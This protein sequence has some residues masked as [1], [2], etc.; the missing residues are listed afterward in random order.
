[1]NEIIWGD[2]IFQLVFLVVLAVIVALI[3]LAVRTL[4]K[5]SKRMDRSVTDIIIAIVILLALWFAFE[6]IGT[7]NASIMVPK[8]IELTTKFILPWIV[9]YWFIRLV[10]NLDK[11]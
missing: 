10:K 6:I 1:M 7:V 8:L 3:V 4:S 5:R 11:S 2:I 9:L